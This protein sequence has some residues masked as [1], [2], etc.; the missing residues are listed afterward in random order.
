MN[1]KWTEFDRMSWKELLVRH[2]LW[3]SFGQL[4]SGSVLN[5][6]K[7]CA[8]TSQAGPLQY[9]HPFLRGACFFP[10]SECFDGGGVCVGGT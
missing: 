2:V 4:W 1:Q 6:V 5:L 7:H 9:F 3:A 8:V 10:V